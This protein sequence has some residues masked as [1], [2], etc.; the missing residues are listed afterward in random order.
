MKSLGLGDVHHILIKLAVSV[1]RDY[2]IHYSNY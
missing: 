1:K 2:M